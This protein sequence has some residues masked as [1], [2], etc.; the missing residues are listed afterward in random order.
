MP[1][2][3]MAYML[4]AKPILATVDAESDTALCI[5][6]ADCGWVGDPENMEWLVS[7]MRKTAALPRDVIDAMGS[8]G[9]AYGLA[10]F[11]KSVGVRRLIDAIQSAVGTRQ[12]Q[13]VADVPE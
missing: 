6:E 7:K 13:G 3:L 4:S 10:H 12:V 5:R 8:Q 1:S 2:K 9:R 11:S